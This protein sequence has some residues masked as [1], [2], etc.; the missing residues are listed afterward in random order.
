VNA[1]SLDGSP[2]LKTGNANHFRGVM[3]VNGKLTLTGT[4]LTF[5]ASRLNLDVYER[6][7]PLRAVT[8]VE[9][10]RGLAIVG[11]G[12]ALLLPGEAEERFVV[13]GRQEWLRE[14]QSARDTLAQHT[15][16]E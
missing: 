2:V 7:Y 15:P 10:R 4:H 3:A 11:D 9:P 14:I 5:R 1:D 12:L 8:G 6:S 16:V 13:F